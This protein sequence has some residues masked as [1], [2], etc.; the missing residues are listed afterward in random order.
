MHDRRHSRYP[1]EARF[2]RAFRPEA[3]DVTDLAEAIRLLLGE[4]SEARHSA[5][6]DL[7]LAPARVSHVVEAISQ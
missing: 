7:P 2:T 5:P 4:G 3:L 1:S 6:A